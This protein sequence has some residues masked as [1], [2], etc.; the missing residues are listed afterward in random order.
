MMGS[1]TFDL[2]EVVT[3]TTAGLIILPKDHYLIKRI[4]QPEENWHRIGK[5][6]CD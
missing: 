4:N 1:L 6:A 2:D 5:S 3:K